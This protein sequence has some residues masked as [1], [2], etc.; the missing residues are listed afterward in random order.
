MKTGFSEG[1]RGNRQNRQK[2]LANETLYQLS[3]TPVVSD[4]KGS[5]PCEFFTSE[6]ADKFRLQ[7]AR[8]SRITAAISFA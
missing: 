7:R 5:M 6:S 8:K 1:I 2:P 4:R 3:Y